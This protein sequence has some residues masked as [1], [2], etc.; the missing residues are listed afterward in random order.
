MVAS[1]A[2]DPLATG[3]PWIPFLVGVLLT[4]AV[5][6]ALWLMG[7]S[8]IA[9]LDLATRLGLDLAASEARAKAVMDSA[10]EAI[11][12]TDAE[13]RIEWTNPAAE[14]LFGWADA[15]LSRRPVAELFPGLVT[16]ATTNGTDR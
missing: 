2:F 12:T 1:P 10:V 16:S 3:L 11:V 4:M 7:R 6:S 15:E 14:S 13:G 8:R 5:S 9:A